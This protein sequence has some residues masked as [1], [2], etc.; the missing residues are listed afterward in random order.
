MAEMPSH[1]HPV[2]SASSAGPGKEEVPVFIVV[3]DT[4]APIL[5]L[6]SARTRYAQ[7]EVAQKIFAAPVVKA[8]AYSAH[9]TLGEGGKQLSGDPSSLGLGHMIRLDNSA[10]RKRS[11]ALLGT[12]RRFAHD[13]RPLNQQFQEMTAA[14]IMQKMV[15]LEL[16]ERIKA[17]A[18]QPSSVLYN[19][20]PGLEGGSVPRASPVR[21]RDLDRLLLTSTS[22]SS[23]GGSS[24]AVQ[25]R[26]R[27]KNLT[28]DERL[29]RLQAPVLDRYP[30]L[31]GAEQ[32][33]H[34]YQQQVE[35]SI[36]AVAAATRTA[37]VQHSR[38]KVLQ[39]Q[40]EEDELRQALL[41]C[42]PRS[43]MARP[44]ASIAALRRA[45]AATATLSEL[46]ALSTG[47]AGPTG[48]H[49][50]RRTPSG[51]EMFT[52][53]PVSM[54]ADKARLK[55]TREK[56]KDLCRRRPPSGP[57]FG[58][59]PS[60]STAVADRGVDPKAMAPLKKFDIDHNQPVYLEGR[61]GPQALEFPDIFK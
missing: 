29:Q 31:L 2:G 44:A 43:A 15:D 61:D 45:S 42:R 20:S 48:P 10:Q 13:P 5:T 59:R 54:D 1:H 39:L 9:T 14:E 58:S 40:H 26:R 6:A 51:L 38:E 30:Q 57:E 46:R 56:V 53:Q 21:A 25:G 47:V 7:D 49:D 60:M 55:A 22:P 41:A 11:D 18:H 17:N 4:K 35:A 36:A 52:P 34:D 8:L 24:E 12:A 28:V 3:G 37:A 23:R 50:G 19:S 32:P 33:L 27:P 16:E